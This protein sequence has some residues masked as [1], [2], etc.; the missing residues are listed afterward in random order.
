MTEDCWWLMTQE[1]SGGPWKVVKLYRRLPSALKRARFI[2]FR[3]V[4]VA[5]RYKQPYGGERL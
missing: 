4:R 3:G 1:V 2:A 5:V